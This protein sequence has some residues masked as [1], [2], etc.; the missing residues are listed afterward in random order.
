MDRSSLSPLY[1]GLL[2]IALSLHFGAALGPPTSTMSTPPPTPVRPAPRRRRPCPASSTAPLLNTR[3][4]RGRACQPPTAH[5]CCPSLNSGALSTRPKLDGTTKG[6]PVQCPYQ[7][8]LPTPLATLSSTARDC[9]LSHSLLFIPLLHTFLF[10]LDFA[11]PPASLAPRFLPARCPAEREPCA[12]IVRQR[13]VNI[14]LMRRLPAA[15]AASPAALIVSPPVR[16][17][18]RAIHS[19]HTPIL[20]IPTRPF[21]FSPLHRQ[22]R[23]CCP[24][25]SIDSR[26]MFP[27]P[28]PPSVLHAAEYTAHRHTQ[29]RCFHALPSPSHP[30]LSINPI[31]SYLFILTYSHTRRA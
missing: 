4:C 18:Y 2:R 23:T 22:D 30:I 3:P 27:L 1:T 25:L 9:L 13:R 5:A 8:Q 24:P 12:S 10:S 15:R 7:Y 14:R 11:H 21:S 26:S 17:P 29:R 19:S 6:A 20:G 16:T 28:L 31:L